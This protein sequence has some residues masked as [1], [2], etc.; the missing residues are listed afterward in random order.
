MSSLSSLTCRQSTAKA[1]PL[2]AV[3]QCAPSRGGGLA[4]HVLYISLPTLWEV[5]LE[6]LVGASEQ[7]ELSLAQ[8]PSLEGGPLKNVRM[9]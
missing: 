7:V 8:H 5:K 3:R 9:K 4:I 1:S 2:V 6:V